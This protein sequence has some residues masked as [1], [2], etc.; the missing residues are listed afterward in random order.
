VPGFRQIASISKKLNVP[1]KLLQIMTMFKT[2]LSPSKQLLH[3]AL[4][5]AQPIYT[6]AWLT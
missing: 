1:V 3:E 5:N 6:T 4:F 2:V